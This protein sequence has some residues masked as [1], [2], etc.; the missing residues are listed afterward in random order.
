MGG[1]VQALALPNRAPLVARVAIM[2]LSA[3]PA[4]AAAPPLTRTLG[5][6][7]AALLQTASQ[8]QV[9][10]SR[11]STPPVVDGHLDDPMWNTA[12]RIDQFSQSSPTEGG[13]P[14]EHTD[15]WITYDN[16]QLYF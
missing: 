6:A 5:S 8:P 4:N 1:V 16:N 10:I 7:Q 11:T 3:P 9:N 2:A 15:I 12:Q 14:T 13:A